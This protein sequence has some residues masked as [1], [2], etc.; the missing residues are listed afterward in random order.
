MNICSIQICFPQVQGL[1]EGLLTIGCPF[2]S[3]RENMGQVVSVS[4]PS[5]CVK[6]LLQPWLHPAGFC[7]SCKWI[8]QPE[9]KKSHLKMDGWNINFLFWGP[10]YFQVLFLAVSLSEA[11]EGKSY[12]RQPLKGE[13]KH[14]KKDRL[15]PLV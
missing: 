7:R 8:F 9:S 14:L 12:S 3:L 13:R 10:A 2:I 4:L 6:L 11:H 1:I 5:S 15:S